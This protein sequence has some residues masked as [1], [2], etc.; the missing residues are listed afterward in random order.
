M[1]WK[2]R[3]LTDK[4]LKEIVSQSTSWRDLMLRIGL[5]GGGS[6]KAVKLKVT[7]LNID[8]THFTGQGWSK[9]KTK[10]TKALC[11]KIHLIISMMN[12]RF[13]LSRVVILTNK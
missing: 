1:R 11:G 7:S 10:E 3:S 8:T 4:R 2:L 12:G 5:N 13:C 6:F 9:G